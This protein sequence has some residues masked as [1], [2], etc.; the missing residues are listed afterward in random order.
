MNTTTITINSPSSIRYPE[1]IKQ[2]VRERYAS[3]ESM[4]QLARSVGCHIDN[5]K[6]WV[7]K[8]AEHTAQST[9]VPNVVEMLKETLSRIDKKRIVIAQAIAEL[10]KE[11]A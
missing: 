11:P 1:E 3:G 7:S 9:H 2:Q 8:R 6:A 4:H 5:V 10:E